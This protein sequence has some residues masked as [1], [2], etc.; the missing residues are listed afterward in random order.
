[1]RL[2]RHRC[3]SKGVRG[4]WSHGVKQATKECCQRSLFLSPFYRKGCV[5]H[6]F[7]MGRAQEE[8]PLRLPVTVPP[9]YH[10]FPSVEPPP[11]SPRTA[12]RMHFLEFNPKAL[13]GFMRVDMRGFLT[14]PVPRKGGTVKCFIRR[15]KK[16]LV[17]ALQRLVEG[18]SVVGTVTVHCGC[19]VAVYVARCGCCC[20]CC[21]CG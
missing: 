7:D 16:E 17:S 4:Q 20:C 15:E 5:V 9:L 14:Q 3:L 18:V 11:G 19:D 1:M 13:E 8:N 2:F 12:R 6:S 21:Y 10:A